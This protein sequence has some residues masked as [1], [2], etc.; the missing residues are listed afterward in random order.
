MLLYFRLL[1]IK[2]LYQKIM[3]ILLNVI[4]IMDLFLVLRE[5]YIS[6]KFLSKGNINVL[7]HTKTYHDKKHEILNGKTDLTLDE[8]EVYLIN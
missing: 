1:I 2:N 6:D 3:I 8:L 7:A 5:T 4:L